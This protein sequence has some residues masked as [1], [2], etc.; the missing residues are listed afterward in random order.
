MK[1]QSCCA[2]GVQS[3]GCSHRRFLAARTLK[4]SGLNG[5]KLPLW[6]AE[7]ISVCCSGRF[8]ITSCFRALWGL[9]SGLHGAGVTVQQ[10]TAE[11]PDPHRC[12][13][14]MYQLRERCSRRTGKGFFLIF[15]SCLDS[16]AGIQ[17]REFIKNKWILH[18]RRRCSRT[19]ALRWAVRGSQLGSSSTMW[20]CQEMELS[21]L[22]TDVNT[23]GVLWFWCLGL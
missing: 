5:L 23:G 19:W 16:C 11:T 8:G 21:E 1:M 22:R 14:S 4:P 3:G 2:P 12:F 15:I 10:S 6:L 9:R 20:M 13:S 7:W 18:A 17:P